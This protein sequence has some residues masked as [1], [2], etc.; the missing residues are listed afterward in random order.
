MIKWA[1]QIRISWLELVKSND[2]CEN[3]YLLFFILRSDISYFYI[4]QIL[5]KSKDDDV[6]LDDLIAGFK[7]NDS[8]TVDKKSSSSKLQKNGNKFINE[9]LPILYTE[10]TKPTDRY[11]VEIPEGNTSI[12]D[13]YNI[14]RKIIMAY[15]ADVNLLL[16]CDDNIENIVESSWVSKTP[17]HQQAMEFQRDVM[18]SFLLFCD[19]FMLIVFVLLSRI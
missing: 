13:V 12:D 18:V 2:T 6:A 19:I 11:G 15:F 10:T 3:S 9:N 8:V 17:L 5:Q 7:I 1:E 4:L 16:Q 14:P